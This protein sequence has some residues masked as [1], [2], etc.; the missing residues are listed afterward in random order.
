MRVSPVRTT[1]VGVLAAAVA[2]GIG[3]LPSRSAAADTSPSGGPVASQG[4]K[5]AHADE[6]PNPLEDKRRDLRERALTNV[7]NGSVEG[8]AARR[9]QGGQGR[10]GGRRTGGRA[11]RGRPSSPPSARTSTSSWRAR[12]PTRS[13]SSWPSSATSGTRTSRTRT[14]TRTPP[15]RPRFDGPLHNAIP[16]AGPDYR[17]LDGLA[18]RLLT[19]QHY[20]E[21]YFGKGESVKTYYEKQSSGRYSVDGTVSDWVKVPY[22]EARYGRSNGTRAPTRSAATPGA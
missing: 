22:N 4:A 14:P 2:I 17:Q 1:A 16:A 13:S 18:G 19:A 11:R 9:Q 20:R 8:R 12:R 3:Q 7:L 21:L 15:G 6:L 10:P 5:G